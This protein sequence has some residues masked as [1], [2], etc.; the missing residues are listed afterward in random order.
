MQ[1]GIVDDGVY[2]SGRRQPGG[3]PSPGI[4]TGQGRQAG[5]RVTFTYPALT[6]RYVHF[7][8]LAAE[9]LEKVC[10]G[11]MIG[12][13]AYGGWR[14]PPVREKVRDNVVIGYVGFNR[15]PVASMYERDR[16]E[17]DAWAKAAPHIFLRPNLLHYGHGYPLFYPE[18]LGQTIRHCAET[19]MIGVDFDSLMRHWANQG[20]NYYVLA[21]LLWNPS[22]GVDKLQ[23]RLA[24]GSGVRMFVH[25]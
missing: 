20:V 4:D 18:R 6:D 23:E 13:Y 10:P 5:K 1:A 16:A 17:W 22:A 2:V 9:R 11:K 12:G 24:H 21:K 14:T 8:N 15:L 19:G 3:W 25:A 7:Y